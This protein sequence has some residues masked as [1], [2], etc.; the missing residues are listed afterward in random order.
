[1]RLSSRWLGMAI[2]VSLAGCCGTKSD[3]KMCMSTIRYKGT[4]A[5]ATSSDGRSGT[6]LKACRTYCKT[7]DPAIKAAWTRWKATPDGQK[8][9]LDQAAEMDI[10]DPVRSAVIACAGDCLAEMTL[11][12]Q[13]ETYQC[14]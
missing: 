8:S 4:T 10:H 5:Q 12:P 2:V 1:M 7:S 6:T 14:P 13:S 11:R 3:E 9:T